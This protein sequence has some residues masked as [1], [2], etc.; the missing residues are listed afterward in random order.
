MINKMYTQYFMTGIFYEI[1]N[2]EHSPCV[3]KDVYAALLAATANQSIV[4]AVTGKRI[5][6]LSGTLASDT[7]ASSITFKSASGGT[8]KHLFYLPA[9]PSIIQIP[10]QPWGAF[11]TNSGEGLFADTGGAAQRVS[12]R[13]IEVTV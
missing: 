6:V 7:V 4:P 13:Y 5:V 9:N 11:N 8:N 10:P 12:L 2:G 1:I 3:V